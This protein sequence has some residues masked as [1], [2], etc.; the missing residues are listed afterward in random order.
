MISPTFRITGATRITRIATLVLAGALA[1]PLA[2]QSGGA[3]KPRLK[4]PIPAGQPGASSPAASIPPALPGRVD[5]ADEPLRLEQVGLTVLVPTNSTV[6][7]TRIGGLETAQIADKDSKWVINVQTPQASTPESS[8]TTAADQTIALIQGSV[9]V[10]DPSQTKVVSTEAKVLS[11]KKFQLAG[12]GVEQFYLSVPR[13]SGDGRLVKGY[14]IFKPSAAQ[15]VVLELI[16]TEQEFERTRVVY[17]TVAGTAAFEDMSKVN[18]ARAASVQA[19]MTLFGRLTPADWNAM[20][21][22]KERWQRLTRPAPGGDANDA[23][24]MGYRGL[25]F[26]RGSRGEIDPDRDPATW[27]A[28]DRDEGYLGRIRV[29]LLNGKDEVIDSE[30]LYFTTPSRADESWEVRTYVRTRAGKTVGTWRE[31]GARAG[32]D[33]T[34]QVEQT[35]QAGRVIKPS[36][37]G[38]GYLGALE[39]MLLPRA[40]IRSGAQTE[41]AFYTYRTQTE[42]V[43]LRRDRL[44]KAKT[45][46]GGWL[47]TTVFREGETEQVASYT[48]LGD[49]VQIDLGDGRVWKPTEVNDLFDLWKRKGLPVNTEPERERKRAERKRERDAGR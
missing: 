14:T 32:R 8:V 16:T 42:T 25:R 36:I 4:G 22:G 41:F 43:S 6:Q 1:L 21:D 34:V 27:S 15:F 35:G 26:W 47:V 24:E 49:L 46:G 17:E 33:I 5:F 38:E 13:A 12:Q 48:A 11:R 19:G 7:S 28:A 37:G 18:E 31:T 3:T 45:P 23:E 30:A 10:T 39:A 20:L 40:M 9:G 29:R 44:E 2:A